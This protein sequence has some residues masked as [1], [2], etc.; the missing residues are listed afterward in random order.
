MKIKKI[1]GEVKN[2]NVLLL[3]GPM[4]SFFNTLDEKFKKDEANT[5]RIGFNAADEYFAKSNQYTGYKDIPKNWPNFISNYYK[6]YKIDKLFVFG[7]CRFYQKYAIKIAKENNIEVY[8]FEEGYLRP[9]FIT[10]EKYGVNDYSTIP[11]NREFYDNLNLDDDVILEIEHLENFG[12]TY[13]KMA[14]EATIYYFLGNLFY[15]KYPNY[16][17]HRCFSFLKEAWVGIV[18]FTRKNINRIKEKHLNNYFEKELTNKYYFVPL[19]TYNDFQIITHSKYNSIEE[20]IKE[21]LISFSKHAPKDKYLVFKHHPMDRGKKNYKKY[22]DFYSNYYGIKHRVIITWDVHLPTLLKHSIGSIMINSTVGIQSLYH[23]APTICLGKAIY[24]IEG[25]TS[26]DLS[27]DEF[28]ENYK[29]VDQ[30]LFRKYRTY[31]IQTTQV[32]SNFYL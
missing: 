32:N 6:T 24:D 11:R 16:K 15:Y 31:L 9:N 4:G 23:K 3:Q 22:I 30:E 29:E 5:F 12:S 14:W 28:W 17:H 18:N 21:V 13:N 2:K 19:Q 7:D 10:L 25:L 27:L 20:F 26:K 1:I 8:V